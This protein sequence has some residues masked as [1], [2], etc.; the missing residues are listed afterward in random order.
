[1]DNR[2]YISFYLNK[3]SLVSKKYSIYLR[4]TI[5]GKREQINT[6]ISVLEQHWDSTKSRIKG[7]DEDSFAS[8]KLLAALHTKTTEIYTDCL[9]QNLPVSAQLIKTKLKSPREQSEYLMRL[10]ELHNAYVN[11]KIGI[12]VTKATYTKYETLKL[13]VKEYIKKQYN[14]S[15]IA[16]DQ[17]NWAS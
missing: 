10:I 2:L 3:Q 16:L 4:L 11:R 6:G 13:K 7:T 9:K 15:D 1:M 8:N 12:E 5:A 17:L 14:E